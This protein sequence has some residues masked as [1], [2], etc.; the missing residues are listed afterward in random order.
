[1]FNR[2]SILGPTPPRLRAGANRGARAGGLMRATN[3]ASQMRRQTQFGKIPTRELDRD[4]RAP[5]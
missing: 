4:K 1:L 2:P 3:Y 5:L